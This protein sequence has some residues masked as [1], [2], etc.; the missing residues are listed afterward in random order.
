MNRSI[1]S[2][3]G[4]AAPQYSTLSEPGL[5]GGWQTDGYMVCSEGGWKMERAGSEK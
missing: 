2:A 5:E 4:W 1:M 3:S